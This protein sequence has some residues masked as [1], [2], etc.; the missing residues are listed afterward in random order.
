M[1]AKWPSWFRVWL[2]GG[3][4]GGDCLAGL[5]RH[6]VWIE[7]GGLIQDPNTTAKI[8]GT[9]SEEFQ[10]LT[11]LYLGI[12]EKHKGGGGGSNKTENVTKPE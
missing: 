6:G 11:L 5:G 12:L 10:I 4:H 2:S 9:L 3:G 1:A 8:P 7:M